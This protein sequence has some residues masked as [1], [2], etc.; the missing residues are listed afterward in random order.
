MI[1]EDSPI[2]VYYPEIFEQDLNGKKQDWEAVVV[3]PFIDEKKLIDAM[4]VEASKL[5]SIELFRNSRG[6]MLLHT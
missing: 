4:E 6:Q 5:N 3:I 2:K 1:N